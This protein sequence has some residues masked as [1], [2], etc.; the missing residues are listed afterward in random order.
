MVVGKEYPQH[1]QVILMLF[2]KPCSTCHNP[3]L[4]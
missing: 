3:Q 2:L 4:Q 1:A